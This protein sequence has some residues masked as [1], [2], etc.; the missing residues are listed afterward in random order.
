MRSVLYCIT[1]AYVKDFMTCRPLS[2]IDFYEYE[3]TRQNV[4]PLAHLTSSKS[5]FAKGTSGES[6]VFDPQADLNRLC[7]R[8]T[9]LILGVLDMSAKTQGETTG[10]FSNV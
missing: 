2:G 5:T 8:T 1:R 6:E 4:L 10:R 3:S 7:F 9:R